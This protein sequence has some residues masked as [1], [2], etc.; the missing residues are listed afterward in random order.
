[1]SRTIPA[2]AGDG[3]TGSWLARRNPTVKV[4]V[5]LAVSLGTLGLFDP[6][7]LV[8]L[9]L[10]AVAAVRLAAR[11]EWRTLLLGQV[12]F[13]LFG[14]GLVAVNALSRPGPSLLPDGPLRITADGLTIGV[15]LALR[16]LVIGVL[17]IGFLASTPPR[18]LMVSLMRQARLSPRYAYAIL[19]GHRMLHAMP[20]RWS[21]IRA[22]H[23]VRGPA[24]RDGRPRFGPVEFGRAAFA[25]LVASIRSSERIALALESRGLGDGPRTVWRPV[26]LGGRDALLAVIV[27]VTFLLVVLAQLLPL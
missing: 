5:L 14:I 9:Y 26:P 1:M 4:A 18:E 21:T 11:V 22:A 20:S 8:A 3:A 24:R 10:L 13:L 17:T 15:A 25:L 19:A 16:G 27:P 23:A 7:P 6:G 2:G 12:P